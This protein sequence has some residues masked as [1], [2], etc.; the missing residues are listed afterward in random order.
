[1]D[2]NGDDQTACK[3]DEVVDAAFHTS[4]T[5]LASAVWDETRQAFFR[6]KAEKVS[7]GVPSDDE[8]D[9]D[10]GPN[11]MRTTF[12]LLPSHSTEGQAAK[13]R[14]LRRQDVGNAINK[15]IE[16]LQAYSELGNLST[17]LIRVTGMKRERNIKAGA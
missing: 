14:E 9:V 11:M 4:S 5:R 16:Q 6:N 17:A 12:N 2:G 7:L 1:M 13:V 15:A 10:P 8:E 3:E